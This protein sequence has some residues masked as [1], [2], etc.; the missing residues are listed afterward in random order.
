MTF[1]RSK[2]VFIV[3]TVSDN[4]NRAWD[5]VKIINHEFKK[6]LKIVISHSSW[7]YAYQENCLVFT[8]ALEIGNKI[9]L[10]FALFLKIAFFYTSTVFFN[11]IDIF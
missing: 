4:S 11:Q 2:Y 7:M 5:K 3:N 8:R 1:V 10:S 6:K 9:R